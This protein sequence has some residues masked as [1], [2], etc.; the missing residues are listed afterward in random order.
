MAKKHSTKLKKPTMY[1][2]A[3]VAGVSQATVSRVLNQNDTLVHISEET[4]QRVLAAIEEL[5][6]RPNGLARSLRMQKTFTVAVLIADLSNSFYHPL[7]RGVQDVASQYGYEVL[8]SNSDHIYEN[9]KHFCEIVARR[10][11]DG[12]VMVP[13]HLTIEDLDAFYSSTSMPIAALAEHVIHPKIDIVYVDDDASTYEAILWMIREQGYRDLGF[14]GVQDDLP[15]GPRRFNGFMRALHEEK[16]EFDPQFKFITDFTI[17]GGIVAANYFINLGKMPRAIYALNDLIAIG[18]MLTLQDAGYR[19]PE[20]VA[21]MGFDNI[22]ET[23]IVRPSLTTIAQDPRELGTL[24]ATALFER[25]A[26]PDKE[27]SIVKCT[28]TLIVRDSA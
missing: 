3:R 7:A 5:G 17:E 14:V 4:R 16:L 19:V 8:I 1:D 24:L 9:E 25:I 10:T 23:T 6:Y 15:P 20:D 21:I 18:L 2:V 13:I 26:N 28:T 12:V 22:P 11:V 27:K